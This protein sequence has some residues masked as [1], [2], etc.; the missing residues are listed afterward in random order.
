MSIIMSVEIDPLTGAFIMTAEESKELDAW[1]AECE[2]LNGSAV[3]D[4]P[5]IVESKE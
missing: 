3:A 2:R 4:T 1:F 5:I